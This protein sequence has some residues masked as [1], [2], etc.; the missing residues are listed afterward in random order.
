MIS[1]EEQQLI[2]LDHPSVMIALDQPSRG[3]REKR[4]VDPGGS[5]ASSKRE[6]SQLGS[7]QGG[8]RPRERVG[9]P[10]K[11]WPRWQLS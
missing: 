1:F 8:G 9:C 5:V 4:E 11:V 3:R 7:C 6:C 2:A 10:Y